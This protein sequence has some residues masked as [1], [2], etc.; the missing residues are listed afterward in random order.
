MPIRMMACFL[1]AAGAA[2]DPEYALALAFVIRNRI[3]IWDVRPDVALDCPWQPGGVGLG[4][5]ARLIEPGRTSLSVAHMAH[6]QSMADPTSG[7]V[8]FH[9]HLESPHWTDGMDPFAL[10]GPCFFYASAPQMAMH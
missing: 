5:A 10:I 3:R 7:G 1:E 4:R 9:H 6:T 2:D 8:V